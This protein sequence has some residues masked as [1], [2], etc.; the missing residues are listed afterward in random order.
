MADGQTD[1]HLS[2]HNHQPAK[3]GVTS[4]NMAMFSMCVNVLSACACSIMSVLNEYLW[5]LGYEGCNVHKQILFSE[6][7]HFLALFENFCSFN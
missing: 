2:E 5:A 6:N 4:L 3:G 1:S 7:L